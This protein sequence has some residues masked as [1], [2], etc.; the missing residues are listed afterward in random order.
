MEDGN[1]ICSSSPFHVP[2]PFAMPPGYSP[3][4]STQCF[5][6]SLIQGLNVDFL[7]SEMQVSVNKQRL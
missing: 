1:L 4:H 5:L 7:R 2:M 6:D 3:L